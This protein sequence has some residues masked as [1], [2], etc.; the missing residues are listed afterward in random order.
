MNNIILLCTFSF[1]SFANTDLDKVKEKMIKE[2]ISRYSGNCPCPYNTTKNG[3]RCGG[4]SAYSKPGG[5][6][7]LCYKI[8]IDNEMVKKYLNLKK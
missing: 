4:R 3:S 7:P 1:L 8:D 2:S 6:A 5:Y